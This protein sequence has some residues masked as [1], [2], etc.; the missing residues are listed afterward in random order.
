MRIFAYIYFWCCN[1][2]EDFTAVDIFHTITLFSSL[3]VRQLRCS[4]DNR[5]AAVKKATRVAANQ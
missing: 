1:T 4:L 2:A 3:D 5:R